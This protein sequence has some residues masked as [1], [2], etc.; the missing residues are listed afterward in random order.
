MQRAL[1]PQQRDDSILCRRWG[2]CVRIPGSLR[3]PLFPVAGIGLW[4]RVRLRR[5]AGKKR[6]GQPRALGFSP[7]ATFRGF[8]CQMVG[9]HAKVTQWAGKVFQ[10]IFR[11]ENRFGPLPD[12]LLAAEAL[13]GQGRS[14]YGID[15]PPLL[16][17]QA[18]GDE[19]PGTAG[20]LHHDHAQ[21]KTADDAVAD[22]E[23]FPQ[24]RCAGSKFRDQQALCRHP[25]I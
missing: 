23:I 5:H 3:R 18:R 21:R 17:R 4:R 2:S 11:R 25:V 14:R 7:A 8:P 9:L 24:G 10:H 22:R 12:K 6:T 1:L 15:F 19:G 20:G 13:T 16:Q